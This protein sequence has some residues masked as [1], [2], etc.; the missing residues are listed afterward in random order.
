MKSYVQYSKETGEVLG[1]ITCPAAQLQAQEQSCGYIEGT[2]LV[3]L[4]YV[5]AGAIV[6]RPLM[7]IVLE[8]TRLS[9]VPLGA[10]IS[11]EHQ[12]VIAEAAEIEL[13][14]LPGR[15]P[16]KVECWPHQAVEMEVIVSDDTENNVPA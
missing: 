10:S 1:M 12:T 14:L 9:G 13:D 6:E 15:Y 5:A 16:V 7:P 11:V 3:D 2:A 4:H 8:G